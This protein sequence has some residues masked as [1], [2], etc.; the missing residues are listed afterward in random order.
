[1]DRIK[2]EKLEVYAGH[3]VYTQEKENG[4][5]FVVSA[6]LYADLREAGRKDE[7]MYSTHYGDVCRFMHTW[8][9][10]HTFLL[11]EAAA[12]QLSRAV[13]LQFPRIREIEIELCKP[14]AQ[15]GIPFENISV[16]L[17][18]GWKQVYLGIGSN[19]GDKK[20]YLE[21]AVA[22]L[23]QNELIREVKCSE[24]MVT[25]P[26][27][28][29]EQDDFLNGALELQTLYDPY[30]L[31]DFLQKLELQAGRERKVHWG[32]R[33]LDLDILFFEDFISADPMLT[34]PHPDLEN[35]GFVLR[36]LAQL[37]PCCRHPVNGKSIKQMLR[38][39]EI[40]EKKRR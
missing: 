5:L 40:E 35:R 8:L 38:E 12:E 37:N 20:R 34:V 19:L 31:L 25:E 22:S 6:V 30:E 23:K 39:L 18:R 13:L 3:G 28:G 15:I 32:P 36:P 7:L 17:K 16:I 10:E 9:R 2:I 29:V 21:N 14:N 1:M 27:G 4:Q 33:T 26:Y 11:I 24:W